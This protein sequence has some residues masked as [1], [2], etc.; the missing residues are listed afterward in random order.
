MAAADTEYDLIIIGGG[1]AGITAAVRALELDLKT[2]ILE[3][4]KEEIY[5]CNTR[6]S[7]GVI[8]I[9]FLDPYRSQQDLAE[10]INS[11]SGGEQDQILADCLACNGS[12]FLDWLKGH[13]AKFVSFN[14]QE[15]Y[16]WCVAPPRALRA[17]I[18]WLGR[19]PDVL[20]QRLEAKMKKMGG[21]LHRGTRV[22]SL[23]ID[24]GVCRGVLAESV[25]EERAWYSSHVLIADGGFQYNRKLYE[26]FIGGS[27]DK[28]FQRGAKTGIGDG[29]N[30][31]R[32]IGAQLTGLDKFYGHLLSAD[33]FHSDKVWPYPEIDAIATSGILVDRCGN[34]V[35]DEGRSGVYLTN[36]VAKTSSVGPFF[37]IC[38]TAIWEGPGRSARI[39]AN[40][41]LEKA[42]GTI[43]KSDTIEELAELIKTPTDTLINTVSVY[44]NAID[45]GNL[46]NLP[47]PRSEV[48]RA[49]KIIKPPFIAIPTCPGITY[50]MGGIKTNEKA[51]VISESGRIIPGLLAAGATTGGL[52]GGTQ[53]AY[54][55]G[56]MKSGVFGLIAAEQTAQMLGKLPTGRIKISTNFGAPVNEFEK[57]KDTYYRPRGLAEFPVLR[58]LVEQGVLLSILCSSVAFVLILWIFFPFLGF[59]SI[60]L[61]SFVSFL[62]VIVGIGFTQLVRLII[63]LL[64]PE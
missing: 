63:K 62:L 16:R 59:K 7:G 53:A 6:Q 3:K 48:I 25:S 12:R 44:N 60:V 1:I 36:A 64:L 14:E 9:G 51:Q 37:S 22:N 58:F 5:P 2:I 52:E 57:K 28:V 42:G 31:A 8:H 34:R 45:D 61:G 4:G 41:L 33:A 18:D 50:T 21:A 30:M 56:L 10:I 26:E 19:G 24:E 27:F 46:I 17:G 29:L 49:W 15:G 13:G 55:G 40:P 11:R 47:I 20:L 39:P 54:I 35:A 43:F 32:Q 23:I 38:D